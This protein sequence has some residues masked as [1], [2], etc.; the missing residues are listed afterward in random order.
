MKTNI[1]V[2]TIANQEMKEAVTTIAAGANVM[3]EASTL[4]GP[5]QD[6]STRKARIKKKSLRKSVKKESQGKFESGS[7][8][9][10]N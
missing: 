10:E 5:N 1:V 9:T 2:S 3:R 7:N 8:M 4:K 6:M